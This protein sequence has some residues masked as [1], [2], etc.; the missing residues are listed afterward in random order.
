MTIAARPDARSVSAADLL[1]L[2]WPLEPAMRS[3]GRAVAY[4]VS[5]PSG[6]LDAL[7]YDV[8]VDEL[9]ATGARPDGVW[10]VEG[11][12]AP[13]WSPDGTAL[14]CVQAVGEPGLVVVGPAE[15]TRS[16]VLVGTVVDFD[17]SPDGTR[18]AVLT[19]L[20]VLAL[21]D[22]AGGAR[23]ELP[24]PDGARL[25]RWS[26]NGAELAVVGGTD[27]LDA[28]P[29]VSTV[30]LIDCATG[31]TRELLTWNGPVRN[32]RW[33]PDGSALA[34]V[35]HDRG[36]AGWEQDGVWLVERDGAGRVE[37]TAGHD[38][39]FGRAVRG[40][41]ERALGP[42]PL[43]WSPD[44]ASLLTTVVDG[45][46]SRLGRIGL[47]G[48]LT[49][50]VAG[51]RAV[52]EFAAARSDPAGPLAFT[53]SDPRHPGELSLLEG[54][55]ERQLTDV[56]AAWLGEVE[57]AS[58]VPVRAKDPDDPAAPVVEGW[59]T[60]PSG[61]PAPLVVQVHGGPHHPVGWRFSFDAQRLAALG[62]A[63]LRSNPRGSTG[64]G[65][66]FAEA[67]R[68][69]WGGPDL[70][71]LLAVTEAA[72]R[73][74]GVDGGRAAIVGESY[75]GFIAN[76]AA[77]T[78]DR[79]TAA[80]AENG[81]SEPLALALGPRGPNFWWVEFGA[82]PHDDPDRYRARSAV[83]RAHQVT[84]PLLLIHAE[85]DDNVLIGQS[86]LM[87]RALTDR[88]RSVR[89]VTVPGEGHMVNVF[90]RPSRRLART[91][92]FD[93]FLFEHLHPDAGSLRP[94]GHPSGVTP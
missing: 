22:V 69:N 68:A 9:D 55:D 39:G 42:A 27:G 34:V 15:R 7:A 23:V 44:G 71:D 48:D 47:D 24:V 78:T 79:F 67:L 82:S 93:A 37:L 91:A 18:L 53:W 57:L 59:L 73:H 62:F 16:R 32:T 38:L 75:G 31:A 88:G 17:W 60:L 4:V 84:T 40:D 52:L 5:G 63:V 81:I 11:C 26:T 56:N 33:S 76:W 54:R 29:L 10:L 50:V 89:F 6:E 28:R 72:A 8:L 2:R 43:E 83:A 92:A 66:D 94:R 58:T 61:Q 41:D 20:A 36:A 86:E 51:D 1:R 14:A 21:I 25:V 46:R 77:A 49:D 30:A 19:T 45:G 87:H 12:R 35:G 90:G 64:R 65:R 80:I 13:K 3:D 85:D 74:P 70:R